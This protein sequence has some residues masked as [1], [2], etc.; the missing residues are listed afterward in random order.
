MFL[1]FAFIQRKPSTPMPSAINIAGTRDTPAVRA[2]AQTGNIAIS[3]QSYPL[4]AASIYEPVLA[5]ID[6]YWAEDKPLTI[7]FKLTYFNT[8]TSK[9]IFNII[10]KSE[11]GFEMGKNVVINWQYEEEDDDMLESGEEFKE[12]CAA[13]FNLVQT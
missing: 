3:G 9:Y 7:T 8:S 2:D 1:T 5:W 4:N 6:A 12:I 11:T 13:P 10:K